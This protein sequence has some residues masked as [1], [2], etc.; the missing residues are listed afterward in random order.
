MGRAKGRVSARCLVPSVYPHF[1]WLKIPAQLTTVFLWKTARD[2]QAAFSGY[3]SIFV[4]VY[5]REDKL[6][7]RDWGSE[8]EEKE[9]E[10]DG[11]KSLFLFPSSSRFPRSRAYNRESKHRIYGKRQTTASNYHVA[12]SPSHL[13]RWSLSAYDVKMSAFTFLKTK[14]NGTFIFLLWYVSI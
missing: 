14:E 7:Q 1:S 3:L 13:L 4:P 5:I 10:K 9:L 2:S 11:R 8:R 12:T 6:S